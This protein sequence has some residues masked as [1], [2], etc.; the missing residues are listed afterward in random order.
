MIMMAFITADS[1][2]IHRLFR[3]C[4]SWHEKDSKDAPTRTPCQV[5]MYHTMQALGWWGNRAQK[6]YTT[7]SIS[8]MANKVQRLK[9]IMQEHY[10]SV[11]PRLRPEKKKK[12]QRIVC[13][14]LLY[15]CVSI[16][17]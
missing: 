8:C 1:T 7:I 6:L 9:C 2:R 11:C 13:D 4:F 12:T 3:L 15:M 16:S 14:F 10:L 17:I 5:D